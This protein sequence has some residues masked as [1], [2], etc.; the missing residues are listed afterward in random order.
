MTVLVRVIVTA[1]SFLLGGVPVGWLLVRL[2]CGVDVRRHGSGNIGTANVTRVA[3]GWIGVTVLIA[4]AAKGFLPVLGLSLLG[5]GPAWQAAGALAAVCGHVW[6]PFLRFKGGK[7]VATSL[8]ALIAISPAAAVVS[9]AAWVVTVTLT[10]YSSAGSLVGAA[11]AA[12]ALW[13]L[14]AAPAHVAFGAAGFALIA[15]RHRENIARLRAGEELPLWPRA[16][17]SVAR[18]HA[19]GRARGR[20]SG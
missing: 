19:D 18:G 3:G 7:G 14:G 8:G 6:S 16:R 17:A 10:R 5:A 2:L 15:V 13:W 1:A 20:A 12:P 4:D 9:A 11:A